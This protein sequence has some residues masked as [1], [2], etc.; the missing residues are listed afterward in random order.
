[1]PGDYAWAHLVHEKFP[2]LSWEPHQL[3]VPS[4]GRGREG[5]QDGTIKRNT[6]SLKAAISFCISLQET[7]TGSVLKELRSCPIA[8]GPLPINHNTHHVTATTTPL[9]PLLFRG[10]GSS[11]STLTTAS[12]WEGRAQ[13]C[14]E[15]VL[16]CSL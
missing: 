11:L 6:P 8:P 4:G 14:G 5:T 1:M 7:S 13:N 2:A 16:S 10:H 12:Y 9:S 3:L 15:G